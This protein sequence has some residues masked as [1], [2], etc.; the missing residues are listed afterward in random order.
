MFGWELPPFNSGG[1]GTACEGLTKALS[2]YDTEIY[3]VLPKNF[4]GPQAYPWM[5][6]FDASEWGDSEVAA[7][8]LK[9]VNAHQ[10]VLLNGYY[11]PNSSKKNPSICSDCLAN[12]GDTPFSHVNY[13]TAQAKKIAQ[14]EDFDVVHAHDWFTYLGAVEAKKAAA[15]KGRDIPLVL[16]VHATQV[17]RAGGAVHP[18]DAIYQ[19]EKKGLESADKIIAVSNHTKNIVC[20]YYGIDPAKVEVVHNGIDEREP[21]DHSGHKLKEKFRNVLFFGRITLQKGPDYYLRIA[22]KVTERCPD[23]KFLMVGSGDMEEQM[24][25]EAAHLNLTGKVLFN[26]FLRHEDIDRIYQTSHVFI[27]PSI[28]EPFGITPLEAMQNGV[29]VVVSKT[30][31][32][33][34]VAENMVVVDFWDV[35]KAAE[36]IIRLLEDEQYAREM[37]A[38]AKEEIKKLTWKKAALKTKKVYKKAQ[39][40]LAEKNNA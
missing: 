20:R 21:V 4:A 37:A 9:L 23:V 13:Y 38:K 1:L 5:R 17:D 24:I 11:Q 8:C 33:S 16:H 19:I 15:E 12:F 18:G 34:E 14:S 26:S 7:R 6:V 30:S 10:C 28:S 22:Q 27:L 3:F 36:E 29:P 35:D 39:R 32:V 25:E 2:F 31:G 40:E